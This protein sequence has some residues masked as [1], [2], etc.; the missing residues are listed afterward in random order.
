MRTTNA[1]QTTSFNEKVIFGS[2]VSLAVLW[3]FSTVNGS[4]KA[5]YQSIFYSVYLLLG[6]DVFV[7][8]VFFSIFFFFSVFFP[9]VL[10]GA[11]L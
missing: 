10:S 11:V 2:F 6:L 8:F 4:E 7:V 3:C 9:T 1:I 5:L